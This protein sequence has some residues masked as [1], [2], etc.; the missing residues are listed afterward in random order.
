MWRLNELIHAQYLR[1]SLPFIKVL[2]ED[3]VLKENKNRSMARVQVLEPL[4]QVSSTKMLF[5]ISSLKASWAF[6]NSN[7]LCFP[8]IQEGANT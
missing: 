2:R 5:E 6:L 8:F 3:M 4:D 7:Y 1:Q